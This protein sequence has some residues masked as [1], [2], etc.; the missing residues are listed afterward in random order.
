[1]EAAERFLADRVRPFER[2]RAACLA[3]AVLLELGEVSYE[4]QEVD[5]RTWLTPLQQE[6]HDSQ[7][8]GARPVPHLRFEGERGPV[9]YVY[10]AGGQ[11]VL[12]FGASAEGRGPGGHAYGAG[13]QWVLELGEGPE[14]RELAAAVGHGRA[15][16][17]RVRYGAVPGDPVEWLRGLAAALT[18]RH[19]AQLVVEVGQ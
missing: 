10:R 18:G 11:W 14:G 13:G 8:A 1:M 4:T 9:G 12:D 7:M 6:I 2:D 17:P 16:V 3:Y 5:G 19:Q 15:V